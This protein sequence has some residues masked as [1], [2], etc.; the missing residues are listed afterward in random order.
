MCGTPQRSTRISPWACSAGS[1]VICVSIEPGDVA[2]QPASRAAAARVGT[3]FM[4]VVSCV[5]CRHALAVCTEDPPRPTVLKSVPHPEARQEHS[6]T[7]TG[8]SIAQSLAAFACAI[9]PAELP[10]DV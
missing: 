9:D 3:F 2:A 8:P 7:T 4:V 1:V 6:M 10:A 5:Q